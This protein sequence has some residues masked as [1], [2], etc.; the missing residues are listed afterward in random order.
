MATF[1]TVWN[2][3]DNIPLPASR[4][5]HT[6]YLVMKESYQHWPVDPSEHSLTA[7]WTCP[8]SS[9]SRNQHDRAW[10][11]SAWPC[12][13]SPAEQHPRQPRWRQKS[14]KLVTVCAAA[15]YNT[16]SE[17][18]PRTIH[19]RGGGPEIWQTHCSTRLPKCSKIDFYHHM[20]HVLGFP[21][22]WA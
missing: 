2:L 19:I 5:R 8:R 9:G 18:K 3:S 6:A 21:L 20:I 15:D 1:S 22:L 11:L 14:W 10:T 17:L 13:T 16:D 4:K 7:S 12:S